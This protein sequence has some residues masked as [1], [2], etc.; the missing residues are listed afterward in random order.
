MLIC[1]CGHEEIVYNETYCPLC[2]AISMRDDNLER[3]EEL[4]EVIN[5]LREK[6]EELENE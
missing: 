1:D 2:E 4:E 3:V 6:I 5:N